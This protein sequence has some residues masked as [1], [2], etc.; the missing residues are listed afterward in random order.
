MYKSEAPTGGEGKQLEPKEIAG[1]IKK[2]LK[3]RNFEMV[4]LYLL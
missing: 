1:F 3:I 4:V 2:N